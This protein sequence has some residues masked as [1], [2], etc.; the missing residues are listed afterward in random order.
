[1]EC[2]P[3]DGSGGPAQPGTVHAPNRHAWLLAA[4]AAALS[5]TT[6]CPEASRSRTAVS[7]D[8]TKASSHRSDHAGPPV[9]SAVARKAAQ[10]DTDARIA[11]PPVRR[12]APP[13][14]ATETT[15]RSTAAEAS[16]DVLERTHSRAAERRGSGA[17][18]AR[19]GSG[20]ATLDPS[21]DG[22][23]RPHLR[24]DPCLRPFAAGLPQPGAQCHP[25]VGPRLGIG[26][27]GLEA[28]LTRLAG[29]D[30]PGQIVVGISP[31]HGLNVTAHI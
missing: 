23:R 13:Q 11:A 24:G 28:R 20:I 19:P 9:A 18:A 6:A 25:R 7:S 3:S 31:A 2:W 30:V 29:A 8:D 15:S 17:A 16:R 1:M 26:D 21:D 10:S 27:L 22:F 5:A 14:A 12:T 4:A